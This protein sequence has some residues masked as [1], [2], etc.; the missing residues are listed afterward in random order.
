LNPLFNE[1]TNQIGERLRN[2]LLV[3]AVDA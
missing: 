3:V 2:F 1:R